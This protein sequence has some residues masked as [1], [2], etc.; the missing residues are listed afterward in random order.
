M[1]TSPSGRVAVYPGTFDPLTNGHVD[2]IHRG[3]NLFDRLI[4]AVG[5]NP[6]KEEL[7]SPSER[8]EMIRE[9]VTDLPMG[10]RIEDPGD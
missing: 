9:M 3:Q 4:V 7:F 2:I 1:A 8:A 6:E 10:H 5:H